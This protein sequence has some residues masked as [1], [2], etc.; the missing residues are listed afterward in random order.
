LAGK[1][2]TLDI[3]TLRELIFQML[4]TLILFFFLSKLLYKPVSN[5]MKKRKEGIVH[6]IEEA[7]ALKAEAL[8]MKAEY[9]AK[10]THVN[11]EV[12][13]ILASAY[14]KATDNEMEIMKQAKE[15]ATRIRK[16][17]ELDIQMAKDQVKDHVKK[18]II[19][20]A[21][22]MTR[23]IIKVTVNEE[24]HKELIEDAIGEI[25]DVKWLA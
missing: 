20:V 13:E 8:K 6:E 25:G 15:E 21:N 9:E 10:M 12:D 2:V 5:F 14:K 7:H 18:E 17:A 3:N 4:N 22:V 1:I 23:K 16:R 11:K 19:Q 24:K